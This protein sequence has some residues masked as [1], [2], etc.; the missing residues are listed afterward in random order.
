[1]QNGG[2]SYPVVLFILPTFQ[3]LANQQAWISYS[4]FPASPTSTPKSRQ[5]TV[6]NPS[7][8][9]FSL[10]S[11]VLAVVFPVKHRHGQSQ[12]AYVLIHPHDASP[13][14]KIPT[15]RP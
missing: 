4:Y 6:E 2:C 11:P 9:R 3:Y 1:H 12:A 10:N 7:N 5:L 13:S 8:L 15:F 14:T